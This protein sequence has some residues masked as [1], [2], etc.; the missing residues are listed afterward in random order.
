VGNALVGILGRL[1]GII[2]E[3]VGISGG[4]VGKISTLVGI[5]KNSPQT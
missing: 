1:V 4:L 5:A 2:E 3:V